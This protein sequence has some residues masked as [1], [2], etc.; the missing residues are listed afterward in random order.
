[1]YR[2]INDKLIREIAPVGDRDALILERLDHMESRLRR[3]DLSR[4][5][6]RSAAEIL[7]FMYTVVHDSDKSSFPRVVNHLRLM[8]N[9][10]V[11]GAQTL[12]GE[13][14]NIRLARPLTDDE[15]G[16]VLAIEGVESVVDTGHI[17]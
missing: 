17:G 2:A 15:T 11:L 14:F 10:Q 6:T 8:T 3:L 7:G 4:P 9:Q 1:M 16:M 5:R 13:S 12:G